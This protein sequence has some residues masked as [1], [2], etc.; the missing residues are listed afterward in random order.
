MPYVMRYE[1][2]K[3]LTE[4]SLKIRSKYL[5]RVDSTLQQYEKTHSD[6][7]LQKLKIA[8]HQWKMS[9]GYDAPG[10][11][12]AWML[13]DRNKKRAVETLDKQLF[14]IP[15]TLNQQVLNDLA[16]LP[17]Y[18]I[19]AWAE[20]QARM[21]MKEAREQALEEMFSGRKVIV[22]KAMMGYAF[23]KMKRD[24]STAK[25]NAGVAASAAGKAVTGP[26]MSEAKKQAM[27]LIQEVLGAYPI[28]VA[29]EVIA[30][31]TGEIPSFLTEL[32]A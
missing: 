12:P 16:E 24:A 14:G 5:R 7:D 4:V 30:Y 3:S 25:A 9:K 20:G 1:T 29:N 18:G 11:K 32:A 10:G 26:L 17:F 28:E 21:A 27:V 22:K 15:E 2:W 13:S 6:A 23:D 19:E 31:I 8:L